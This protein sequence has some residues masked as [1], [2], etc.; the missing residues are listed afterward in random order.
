MYSSPFTTSKTLLDHFLLNPLTCLLHYT[1]RAHTQ[2]LH[3][4]QEYA[5]SQWMDWPLSDYLV[6]WLPN[7]T[8][9]LYAHST[10][11]MCRCVTRRYFSLNSLFHTSQPYRCSPLCMLLCPTWLIF[12]MNALLHISQLYGRSPQCMRVCFIRLL[13]SLYDL[14]HT[15]QSW[16]CSPVCMCWWLFRLLC[17]LNALLHT[18]QV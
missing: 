5:E 4:S 13:L 15:S 18:L 11:C 3:K 9:Q 1:L 7:N 10:L 16:G 6:H 12:P 17:W 8:N 2:R 14:L